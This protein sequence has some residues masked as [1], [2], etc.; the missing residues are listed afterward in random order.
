M[1]NQ[2]YALLQLIILGKILGKSGLAEGETP[3]W[4]IYASGTA[5]QRL[6]Y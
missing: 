4:E 6:N 5:W 3:G 2:K 1:R